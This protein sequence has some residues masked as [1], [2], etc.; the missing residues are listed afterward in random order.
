MMAAICVTLQGRERINSSMPAEQLAIVIHV[1][2]FR[3]PGSGAPSEQLGCTARL[4]DSLIA[5]LGF[6]ASVGLID[7]RTDP[8]R[9]ERW[10]SDF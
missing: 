4:V 6:P 7:S 9:G 8:P 3:G 2:S 5:L 1:E 10:R